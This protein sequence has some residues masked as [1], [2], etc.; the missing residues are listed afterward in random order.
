MAAVIAGKSESDRARVL[1]SI[2]LGR[3]G[4]PD[5]VAAAVFL[6]ESD[7]AI[8]PGA[9]RDAMETK[10]TATELAKGLSDVLNRVR[11]RGERFLVERGGEPVALLEPT[12]GVPGITLRGLVD[13]L[14]DIPLADEGFADDLEE[15]Q[16]SQPSVGDFEW[17]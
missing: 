8:I 15:I 10:I 5:E 1:N 12:E 4:Q 7:Y 3:V 17:R 14:R 11:Y 16:S 9:G 2:P 13:R 6:L